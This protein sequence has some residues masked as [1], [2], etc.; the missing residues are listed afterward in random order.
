MDHGVGESLMLNDAVKLFLEAENFPSYSSGSIQK[1]LRDSTVLQRISNR[2]SPPIP[3]EILHDSLKMASP[4]GT[5]VAM[6]N[7]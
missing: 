1:I 2:G 5:L 6:V 4:Q 3:S 7:I